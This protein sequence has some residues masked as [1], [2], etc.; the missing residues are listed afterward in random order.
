MWKDSNSSNIL[1]KA[2]VLP[3][4]SQLDSSTYAVLFFFFLFLPPL[5]IPLSSW[6]FLFPSLQVALPPVF[7]SQKSF[8]QNF[9]PQLLFPIPFPWVLLHASL[10]TSL[11]PK[12]VWCL[13][14][15]LGLLLY[16]GSQRA[17]WPWF[18]SRGSSGLM[19]SMKDM[20]PPNITPS[21]TY[22]LLS[23]SSI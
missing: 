16:L 2:S 6:G 1:E 12:V 18:S 9:G 11:S 3:V 10:I 20:G 8:F 23:F 4:I 5:L 14:I 7:L 21:S 15:F 22:V 19:R 13:L 17:L